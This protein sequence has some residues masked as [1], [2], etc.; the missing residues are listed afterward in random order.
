MS[1]LWA[2][3]SLVAI[4]EGLFLFVTPNGWKRMAEQ[5]HAMPEGRLRVFGGMIVVFGLLALHY[6]RG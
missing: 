3:L 4:L 2:A 5:L 6:C 1:D